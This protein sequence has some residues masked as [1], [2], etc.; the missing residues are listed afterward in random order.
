MKLKTKK[1]QLKSRDQTV[2]RIPDSLLPRPRI[3]EP[4]NN[5]LTPVW[6]CLGFSLIS[7]FTRHVGSTDCVAC[8]EK[9]RF[10]VRAFLPLLPRPSSASAL[11]R[12]PSLLL[13]LQCLFPAPVWTG[14]SGRAVWGSRGP[15]VQGSTGSGVCDYGTILAALVVMP[16]DST[17]NS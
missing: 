16:Q 17:Y 12:F 6:D 5:T 7:P 14:L 1:F 11:L 8:A 15:G 10:P 3:H 9:I 4:V 13:L 2:G